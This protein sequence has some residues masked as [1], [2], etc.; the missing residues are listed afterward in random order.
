MQST[1]ATYTLLQLILCPPIIAWLLKVEGDSIVGARGFVTLF[2]FDLLLFH[3]SLEPSICKLSF[4]WSKHHEKSNSSVKLSN[5]G[6]AG[7]LL[8]ISLK[9]ISCG[10]RIIFRLTQYYESITPE[11]WAMLSTW[12]FLRSDFA[13]TILSTTARS[14]T[15][16][17]YHEQVRCDYQEEVAD[18]SQIGAHLWSQNEIP[19]TAAFL[20]YLLQ[21]MVISSL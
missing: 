18:F 6:V 13:A 21:K 5:L 15:R 17:D 10:Q 7:R 9:A 2:K 14:W 8:K 1:I 16:C 11:C 20:D 19:I 3:I 12:A 4:L